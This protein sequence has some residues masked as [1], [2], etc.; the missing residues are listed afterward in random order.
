M[1]YSE[2]RKTKRMKIWKKS[3]G[4]RE[5]DKNGDDNSIFVYTKYS[6]LWIRPTCAQ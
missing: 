5:F 6:Y 4:L 3:L 2:N 1:Y